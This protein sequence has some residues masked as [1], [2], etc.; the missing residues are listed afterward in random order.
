MDFGLIT[1]L[2]VRGG[3]TSGLTLAPV[4][5]PYPVTLCLLA[6]RGKP[7]TGATSPPISLRRPS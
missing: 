7:A 1:T 2:A 3:W 4:N 6:R 5:A